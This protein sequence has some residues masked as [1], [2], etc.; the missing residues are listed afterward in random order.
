MSNSEKFITDEELEMIEKTEVSKKVKKKI[1]GRSK[2]F[3][4]KELFNKALE[5]LKKEL[6]EGEAIEE[7]IIGRDYKSDTTRIVVA[8]SASYIGPV[9]GWAA[10]PMNDWSAKAIL[11]KTNKRL[12][13]M[14]TAQYFKYLRCYEVENSVKVYTEKTEIYL[15]FVDLK[16]EQKLIELWKEY[17]EGVLEKLKLNN[18]NF[19][20][21]NE[22]LECK[23]RKVYNKELIITWI[24]FF[25]ILLIFLYNFLTKGLGMWGY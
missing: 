20:E 15:E 4:Y 10:L 6:S 8:G 13:I 11:V 3:V 18:I 24:V 1:N 25:I 19:V 12:L 14:E 23:E 16:G 17:K 7:C 22:A 5:E 2:T 21:T 9:G